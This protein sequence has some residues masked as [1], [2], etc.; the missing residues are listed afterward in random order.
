MIIQNYDHIVIKRSK[1]DL[2]TLL[3]LLFEG[4]T[5]D[6]IIYILGATGRS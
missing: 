6:P 2:G 3:C 4:N 5:C 1:N